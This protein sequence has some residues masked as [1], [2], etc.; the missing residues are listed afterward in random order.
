MSSG[1]VRRLLLALLLLL[2]GFG[3]FVAVLVRQVALTQEQ[4]ALQRLSHGL[5][6][7]IVGHW[8]EVTAAGDAAQAGRVELMR[9]LQA[10]NPGVQVYLLDADGAVAQYIGPPGM[11]R[12]HRVNINAVCAFLAGAALPL[13]GTD[14]TCLLIDEQV[15]EPDAV[16]TAKGGKSI[17][18]QRK[19]DRFAI[20]LGDLAKHFRFGPEQIA[21]DIGA[22]RFDFV[23]ELFVGGEVADESYDQRGIAGDCGADKK[24]CEST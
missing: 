5:A 14:P 10:V 12:E 13:A 21:Q 6:R 9:M 11:V 8:P 15:F 18:P 19:A 1:F 3:L 7:H 16:P 2:L 20:P 22:G 24:H 23:Q 4:E 17:E